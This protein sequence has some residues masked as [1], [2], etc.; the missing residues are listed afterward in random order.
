MHFLRAKIT[1]SHLVIFQNILSHKK[2]K[3]KNCILKYKELSQ[4]VRQVLGALANAKALLI[5]ITVGNAK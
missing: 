2:Y 1:V 3:K 5:N 4:N